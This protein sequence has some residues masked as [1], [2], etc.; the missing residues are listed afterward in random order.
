MSRVNQSRR[1]L[2]SWI[3]RSTFAVLVFLAMAELYQLYPFLVGLF[4]GCLVFW[5]NWPKKPKP[6]QCA[7]WHENME[8]YERS[9]N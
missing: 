8:P 1:E 2:I 7:N 3:V 6:H 5:A 4:V 9:M